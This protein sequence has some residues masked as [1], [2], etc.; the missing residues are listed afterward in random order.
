MHFST[1]S[2]LALAMATAVSA[3][4]WTGG[5]TSTP[6]DVST[7]TANNFSALNLV[8]SAITVGQFAHGQQSQ[9]CLVAADG[10]NKWN[11]V[12]KRVSDGPEYM[13]L[14]VADCVDGLQKE[15]TA[16]EHG[17]KTAYGNWEYK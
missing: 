17:G 12:V 10:N 2:S 4:C 15:V 14:S 8:C 16:C 6:A 9:Y 3:E 11:F 1:L 13:T 5:A 7:L